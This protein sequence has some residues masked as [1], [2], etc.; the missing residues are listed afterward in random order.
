MSNKSDW[1]N[2]S[3]IAIGAITGLCIV[4]GL[5]ILIIKL[6]QAIWNSPF[7]ITDLVFNILNFVFNALGVI[8]SI[9][10]PIAVILLL[11]YWIFILYEKLYEKFGEIINQIKAPKG[12]NI[13]PIVIAGF[14][15]LFVTVVK[16]NVI[17]GDVKILLLLGLGTVTTILT[18]TTSQPK[19]T[20]RFG[21]W[22]LGVCVLALLVFTSIRF[23][24]FAPG[25]IRVIANS[26]KNWFV[27]LTGEQY[28]SMGVF[29]TFLVLMIVAAIHYRQTSQP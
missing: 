14:S 19:K 15:G 2:Y 11:G 23:N 4:G 16:E 22:L 26:I 28:V 3:V 1:Q 25:Q 21:F 6:F 24:I 29:V 27:N 12:T 10:G 20:R 13:A 17:P 5:I 9:L 18:M 8:L 7:A